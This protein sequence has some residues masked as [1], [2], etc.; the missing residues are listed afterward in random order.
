MTHASRPGQDHD[1]QPDSASAA[2]LASRGTYSK[3]STPG[4][5]NYPKREAPFRAPVIAC[6]PAIEHTIR[7]FTT[8]VCTTAVLCIYSGGCL[9]LT[10]FT[11]LG[12]QEE[13]GG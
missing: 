1:T 9:Y 4:T 6:E 5:N 3:S 7:A 11:D 13:I 2:L 8:S 12:R 10:M